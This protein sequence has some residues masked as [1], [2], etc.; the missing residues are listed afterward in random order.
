[1]E[2]RR[3]M[4]ELRELGYFDPE[5]K[6]PL[7]AV[8][9]KIAVVT[10]GG[11]AALQDVIDTA[12]RRWPGCRLVLV[13]VR[14]Q[15]KNAAPQIAQALRQLSK[16]GKKQGIDAVIL[17]RGGGSIEDLWA[18]NERVVAD[19]VFKCKLPVVA[20][21]GHETDTTIAELVADIRCAT[22]TQAAMTVVPEAAALGEQVTQ[23]H[24]RLS[25][26]LRRQIEHARQRTEA[27]GRHRLLARPEL[28]IE[29]AAQRLAAVAARLE[30][31]AARRVGEARRQVE[32]SAK[33]LDAV[34]P[35]RV[36]E[37]GFTYTTDTKGNVL[38]GAEAARDAG[39]L[40]TVFADGPVASVVE[41][42]D[43]PGGKTPDRKKKIVKKRSV[44]KRPED[45]GT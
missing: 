39:L 27:A 1:M 4:A 41:D 25:H 44:R 28:L 30:P 31:A 33:H 40:T 42:S 45:S 20:A 6:K 2:L 24:R 43:K 5:H 22:P 7:P 23:L 36:L 12:K 35:A 11:A 29:S 8:P 16:H 32:A 14:V 17:T 9:R 38:R 18:F 26:A 21:I 15:G 3:L 10:S 37:R 19:A 34:G 13:D